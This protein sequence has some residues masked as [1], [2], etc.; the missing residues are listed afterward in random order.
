MS[1]VLKRVLGESVDTVQALP[2][3]ESTKPVKIYLC[4]HCNEEILEKHTYVQEG[5]DHHSDC[6]KPIKWPEPDWSKVA[7]WLRPPGK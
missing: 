7:A 4:P 5:I 1:S 6:G 3:V 2:V